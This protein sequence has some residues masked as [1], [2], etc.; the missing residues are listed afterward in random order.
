MKGK[1]DK[2]PTMNAIQIPDMVSKGKKWISSAYFD[3]GLKYKDS[4]LEVISL[5]GLLKRYN[6]DKSLD[7][8]LLNCADDYQGIISI[9]DIKKYDL[10]IALKIKSLSF[11]Q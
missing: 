11:F 6:P 9:N 7:A 5:S 1:V 10:Q 3:R 4:R 8:I 2:N